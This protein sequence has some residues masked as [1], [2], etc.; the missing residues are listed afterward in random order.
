ME[1]RISNAIYITE[2]RDEIWQ[3]CTH[4]L[5]FP[6]PEYAKKERMGFWTGNVPRQLKMYEII[7][8]TVV[9]PY[10]CLRDIKSVIKGY[11]ITLDLRDHDPVSYQ[12]SPVHLYD[13][14]EI[15]VNEMINKTYG[16]LQSKAG[17]GKTQ[18][19]VAIAQ[20]ID[21]PTLWLTHTQDLLNQSY[22]RACL[23]IKEKYLGTITAG[24]VEVGKFITFATVQTMA[25]LDLTNYQD[26]W[27][28][29][30]VDE[31]H[32]VSSGTSSLSMFYKVLKSLKARHK[33]G[34]SATLDRA[35]G[36]I[37]STFAILGN[38]VYK[39]P[40]EAV[41]DKIMTAKIKPIYTGTKLVEE[42]LNSDGT[43]NH[44][45]LINFLADDDDRTFLIA[46][47]IRANKGHPS[48]ILSDRIDHLELIY[49]KLPINLK[50]ESVIVTGKMNSA[51]GKEERKKALEDMRSGRKTY[52]FSTYPLAKEGLDIPRL[53]RLYLTT[54]HKD[55]VTT[56]Q[57]IGRI[58]RKCAGKETPICYDFVDNIQYCYKAFKKRQRIYLQEGCEI[59]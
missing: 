4:K 11:P 56:T 53:D 3:Y 45:F 16:I 13:Y 38:V 49:S 35:D 27:D 22:N 42:C 33:Y 43:L 30:I 46:E 21:R 9:I 1:T 50:K 59:I 57:A 25:K 10:G 47:T 41:A 19:G 15:A 32:R 23:Y 37:R 20:R 51:R 55:V 17:S 6:N 26:L 48:L 54:P 36:L 44:T 24:K 40:D 58:Q 31:C 18:M 5:T 34:L 39:V 52:L 28:V 8:D 14:Q 29:V 12:G 2:P 7:N